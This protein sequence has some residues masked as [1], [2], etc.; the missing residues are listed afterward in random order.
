MI[1]SVKARIFLILVT[2]ES[3]KLF[4]LSRSEFRC[5]LLEASGLIPYHSIMIGIKI[6]N[7][8]FE[9][10][11]NFYKNEMLIQNQDHF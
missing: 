4:D 7:F 6:N 10:P 8:L 3:K 11:H 5:D 1:S 9:Y 2:S